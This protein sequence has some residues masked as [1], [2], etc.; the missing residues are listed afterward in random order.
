MSLTEFAKSELTEVGLFDDDSD[1]NG[2]IGNCVMD[3]I[4]TLSEQGHSGAS[5]E[6]TTEVF[7]RLARYQPLSPI[8]DK[9]EDWLEV[10]DNLY[11]HKKLAGVFKDEKG[12]YDIDHPDGKVKITFPYSR[13]N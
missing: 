11:Q 5:A 10:T 6:L 13:P 7:S 9:P 3:L 8:Q 12:S 4:K 1:Y 2:M